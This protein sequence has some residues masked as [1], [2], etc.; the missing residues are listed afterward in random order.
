MSSRVPPSLLSISDAGVDLIVEFEGF[1][2]YPYYD[3]APKRGGGYE[4]WTGGPERHPSK[5]LVTIGYG[6]TNLTGLPPKIVPGMRMNKAEAMAVLKRMLADKYEPAVKRTIKAPLYQHEYDALVSFAYNLGPGRL[7]AIAD[8][9]AKG[10]YDAIP[11]II[12]R[13]TKARQNGVLKELR[14]LVRRRRAEAEMWRGLRS[15]AM[16]EDEAI[17]A[18]TSPADPVPPKTPMQSTTNFAALGGSLSGAVAAGSQIKE[19]VETASSLSDAAIAAGP[20][21]LLAIVIG[22]AAW[23]IIRERN[24]KIRED[25]V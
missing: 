20:W 18:R 11:G 3:L 24:K 16:A 1:I 14:G 23:W 21:V 15:V 12:M 5:G 19:A 2:P 17:E 4:E 8:A 6:H 9:V 10:R 7:S 13:Y 22:A 25:F